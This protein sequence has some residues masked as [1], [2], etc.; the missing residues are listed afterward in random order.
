MYVPVFVANMD[1]RRRNVLYVVGASAGVG[2]L[3]GMGQAVGDLSPP[4]GNQDVQQLQDNEEAD[5]DEPDPATEA[6]VA[7]TD[8]VMDELRWFCI[9]YPDA[10]AAYRAAGN[11]LLDTVRAI[12]ESV[13]LSVQDVRRLEAG[14][15]RGYRYN[16]QR[17]EA[18]EHP[19]DADQWPHDRGFRNRPDA[20]SVERPEVDGGWPYDLW[21]W[22]EDEDGDEA[23]PVY[24]RDVSIEWPEPDPDLSDAERYGPPLREDDIADLRDQVANFAETIREELHPQFEDARIDDDEDRTFARAEEWFGENTIDKIERFNEMGDTPVVVLGLQRLVIRYVNR[25]N[26]WFVDNFLSRDPIHNRLNDYLAGPQDDFPALWEIDYRTTGCDFRA[27]AWDDDD[28]GEAREDELIRGSQPLNSFD[29]G[30]HD[31]ID[32]TVQDVVEPLAVEEDRHDH[33][34]LLVNEWRRR[35]GDYYSVALISQPL[36]V[37]RFTS[38][39]AAAD[40]R[41]EILDQDYVGIDPGVDVELGERDLDTEWEPV[42][43]PHEGEVWYAPLLQ[44][45]E[46]LFAV[47]PSK[48]PLDR[49]DEELLLDDWEPA[50]DWQW[51]DPLEYAWVWD[52]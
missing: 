39:E 46:Y 18:H 14:F 3:G 47:A 51:T 20:P 36:F 9:E 33:A 27:Y 40:A 5:D 11:K 52:Y 29:G 34:Y 37:Q 2:I 10:I 45:G 38:P 12:G 49:R 42:H 26:D 23:P 6:L 8:D 41:E 32:L 17:I 43:F 19:S 4:D 35:A 21:D 48:R 25:I 31:P 28:V 30:I 44:A 15:D 13:P 24:W 7:A 1:R 16:G 50:L 22:G